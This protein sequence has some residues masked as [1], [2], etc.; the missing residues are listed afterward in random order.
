MLIYLLLLGVVSLGCVLGAWNSCGRV[1][2]LRRLCLR[3]LD[4]R[5]SGLRLTLLCLVELIMLLIGGGCIS[6]L[7]VLLLV[8][9]CGFACLLLLQLLLLQVLLLLLV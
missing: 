7:L 1:R 6:Y 3:L 9:L 4:V 8:S 2:S 5:C